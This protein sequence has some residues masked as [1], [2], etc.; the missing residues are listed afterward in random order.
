[1]LKLTLAQ[2][3]QWIAGQIGR[4]CTFLPVPDGAAKALATVTGFLPGAPITRDQYVMLC[5]DNVVAPDAKD[6]AR[7]AAVT[8]VRP[9]AMSWLPQIINVGVVTGA[10]ATSGSEGSRPREPRYQLRAAVSAPGCENTATYSS[11]CP[12]GDWFQRT[13][14]AA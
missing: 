13:L 7:E 3:N 9:M 14:R 10:K 2:I 11:S 8:A 5:R 6:A 1:M 12:G 4:K